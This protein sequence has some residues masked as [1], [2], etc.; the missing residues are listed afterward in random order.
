M[1]NLKIVTEYS[2]FLIIK[3]KAYITEVSAVVS[4]AEEASLL[5]WTQFNYTEMYTVGSDSTIKCES[6]VSGH[7]F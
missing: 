5:Y 4:A 6:T 2:N 7:D 1:M 3:E